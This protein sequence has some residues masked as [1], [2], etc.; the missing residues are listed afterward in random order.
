VRDRYDA[1]FE[2][3]RLPRQPV[4]MSFPIPPLVVAL[5]DSL[6]HLDH[7]GLPSAPDPGTDR[8][9]SP[10]KPQLT[11]G[12]P[13]GFEQDAVRHSDLP[14]IMQWRRPPDQAGDG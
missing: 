10:H 9:M 5:R 2:R 1:S 6:R 4:G 3:D 14:H 12:K 8:D 11:G 7:R 13:P